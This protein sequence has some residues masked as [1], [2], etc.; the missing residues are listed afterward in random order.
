MLQHELWIHFK[1]N[2]SYSLFGTVG[3]AVEEYVQSNRL[4]SIQ[5]ILKP[6]FDW[7]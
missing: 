2:P 7:L 1:K 4:V 5:L 6:Q 3:A